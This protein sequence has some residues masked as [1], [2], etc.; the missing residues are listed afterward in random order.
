MLFRSQMLVELLVYLRSPQVVAKTVPLL[1]AATASEDLLHYPFFL[2]YARD[3][4]TIEA[5]REVFDAL[6]R[7]E[8]MS[9]GR[10]FFSSI[11]NVRRELMASLTPEDRVALEPVLNATNRVAQFT[12]PPARFVKDWKLAD[13]EPRLAEVG[14][15]RSFEGARA[16]LLSAQCVLCHRVSNDPS[17]PN[18]VIGPE[19]IG[20]GARVRSEEHT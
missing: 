8:R 1:R 6:A 13:L 2:R 7:A 12:P 18:S 15:G 4:W 20:V 10:T 9:G 19:L 5:R 11:Q 14:K 16:A 3:G 17:F